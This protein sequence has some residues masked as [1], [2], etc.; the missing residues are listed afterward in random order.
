LP[1]I[2]EQAAHDFELSF[3]FSQG[4]RGLQKYLLQTLGREYGTLYPDDVLWEYTKSL[5]YDDI[6]DIAPAFPH[7]HEKHQPKGFKKEFLDTWQAFRHHVLWDQDQDNTLNN[8]QRIASLMIEKDK[9][10]I[11]TGRHALSDFQ[12]DPHASFFRNHIL[13]D[14]TATSVTFDAVFQD[15]RTSLPELMQNKAELVEDILTLEALCQQCHPE[16]RFN[17][18]FDQGNAG[19][20][21]TIKPCP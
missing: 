19:S 16:D 1:A 7:G 14:M 2:H 20:D 9:K 13:L 12:P 18:L 3:W 17:S 5:P 15:I 21:V 8:Y 4:H 10:F 6:R 11:A